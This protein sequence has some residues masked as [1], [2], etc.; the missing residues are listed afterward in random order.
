MK[1]KVELF[2]QLLRELEMELGTRDLANLFL[3]SLMISV[4]SLKVKDSKE[5]LK[6]FAAL[7]KI[8]ENTE[9][10]FG[11]LN[12]QAINLAKFVKTSLCSKKR[13]QKNWR[14]EMIK[15]IKEVLKV[16]DQQKTLLLRHAEEIDVE[17]KRILIHDHS[18]TVQ[19]ALVHYKNIGKK[20]KVVIAE[21]DFEKTH[22][23]IERMH[24]AGISFQVIPSYMLSHVHEQIDMLF[25]GAVT[26]KST[27]NFVMAPGTHSII[28]EFHVEKT[29]VYMFIDATK[30]SLWPAK[31][32]KEVFIHKHEREHHSK[33]IKYKRIKYSH[34]RVPVKLFKKVI[35][36]KGVF[37][38]YGIKEMFEEKISSYA[39]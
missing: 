33:P 13:C 38:S 9:P 4:K 31:K 25:F 17:G 27:M 14:K 23:N 39:V 11:I 8:I 1:S 26:L 6:E 19:D 15:K 22:D 10:K 34:D 29:P 3:K 37:D 24:N 20:F 21:Q 7:E 35:T 5:F 16:Y 28:S 18:H 2:S 30:F 32:K 36:N 12:Y